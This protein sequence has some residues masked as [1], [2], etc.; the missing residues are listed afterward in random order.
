LALLLR[1]LVP[2]ARLAMDELVA[3]PDG[4]CTFEPNPFKPEKCKNCRRPWNEH[5]GVISDEHLDKFV[6]LRQKALKE[7]QQKENEAKEKARQKALLKKKVAQAVE[8]EWLFDGSK[9]ELQPDSDD[10]TGFRML[11]GV[12]FQSAHFERPRKVDHKPLKVVN[13]ID[14]SA[15]DV[16]DAPEDRVPDGSFPVTTSSHPEPVTALPG[17]PI[18]ADVHSSP[19][20]SPAL[21]SAAPETVSS[22]RSLFRPAEQPDHAL[23]AEL[24]TEIQHL[25]QMLADANEERSIQVAIVRDEVL[26]KQKQLEE[27]TRQHLETEV[28]LRDARDKLGTVEAQMAQAVRERDEAGGCRA[29]L[30]ELRAEM[31][32]LRNHQAGGAAAAQAVEAVPD[33]VVAASLESTLSEEGGQEFSFGAAAT[34]AELLQLCARTQEALGCHPPL[35]EQAGAAGGP[36]VGLRGLRAALVATQAAAEALGAERKQ[37]A[38]KL[39]DAEQPQASAVPM[40]EKMMPSPLAKRGIS[41]ESL[42]ARG[43]QATE[44]AGALKEIRLNTE[45]QL[46]WI[47]KR[48]RRSPQAC[49][50]S[51]LR[52]ADPHFRTLSC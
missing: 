11:E 22:V 25:R 32:R 4:C 49:L 3:N 10:D 6:K 40:L 35:A 37:L 48:M 46:A 36:E 42:Q 30:Q 27:L 39:R 51:T 7:Q 33:T 41:R 47:S 16:P 26:E 5:K 17:H 34:L 52:C 23:Q 15:C 1:P 50:A 8:D 28:Q 43:L 20:S 44:M 2:S 21:G 14:F 24:L 13:L 18:P 12:D 19:G 45:Q 29:E 31:E 38:L 9:E